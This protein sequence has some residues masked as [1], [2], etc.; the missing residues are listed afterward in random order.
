MK[1][2]VLNPGATSTKVS[3]FEEENEIFRTNLVHKAEELTPFTHVIEQGPFR[4]RLIL[5]AVEGAGY[6]LTDFDA[7]CGRGGLLR[8]IP[9]GTYLVSDRPSGTLWTRRMG[10]MPPT[11]E[12]CWP[13][14]WG[15]WRG[16][17]RSLWIRCAWMR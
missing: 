5:E 1:V 4:K 14:S 17:L 12:F 11:W 6:R 7:V 13:G 2:L 9:S 8:H 3:I 10:S 16:F 15:T